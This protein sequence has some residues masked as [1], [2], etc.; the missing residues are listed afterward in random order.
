VIGGDN[1]IPASFRVEN[2]TL[3]Q[4]NFPNVGSS[5]APAQYAIVDEIYRPDAFSE[6]AYYNLDANWRMGNVRLFGQIGQTRGK[7][8]T[9]VQHVFEG[10][11]F[12][13]G[14][15]YTMHGLSQPVSVAFPSGNPSVFTG[16]SLDWIFGASP[17][18]TEDKEKYGRID[19]EMGLD[20]GMWNTLKFGARWAEHTR[21]THQVAQGPLFAADPFNPANLPNWNGETYPGDFG[22]RLGGEW[23]R[24]VWMISPGEL[25][26]WGNIYTNRDPVTRQFWPGEFAIKENVSAAYVMA[27]FD[28]P[29]WSGNLGVR[30]VQTKEKVTVN[31]AIPG[32]VC[33]PL[34]PCTV[35]GAITTSAFGSFYK[36]LVENKYNDILPSANLRFDLGNN[37]IGRLAAS[38]TM[39]RPDYSALGGSITADDTTLTG[40]GGNPNLKPIRSNNL[41][42]ALEW[43]YGPRALLSAN[44]FHMKLTNYVAFGTYQTQLLNIRNNTFQTYTISAPVNSSG[45]I[46]GFELAWQ[47]PLPLGFGVQANYTYADAKETGGQDL[48]GA[49]KN[50][51][52]VSAYYENRGFGA[53]LAYTYRSKFFIT[54][55]RASPLNQDGLESLDASINYNLTDNVALTLD[56]VNLTDE[57]IVQYSGSKSRPRAI[58]DNGRQVY[59]GVRLKF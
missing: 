21:D 11:V 56:A 5:S 7:G 37:M 4:A 38:R 53:R 34:S 46:K 13:T 39:A 3:V 54:F 18:K 17:A 8:E 1:R 45:K 47:Q 15:A 20:R 14:A 23:P 24:N 59:A 19:G 49:S 48:V 10:D 26:R 40:N 12:N 28:G 6:T 16:T 30:F 33:A 43:Y 29:G 25:E 51:Y 22:D 52:N 41:D 2:N 42:A 44:V 55:D 57:N 31:V 9:P 36:N 50:T 32:D 27:N 35:P 58:Y